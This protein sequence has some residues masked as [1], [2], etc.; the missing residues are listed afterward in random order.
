[1]PTAKGPLYKVAFRRR[2]ENRTD[3]RKRLG[4]IRSD[5]PRLVV[6]ASNKGIRA[7]FVRFEQAGDMTQAQAG[8]WELEPLGW[9]PQANAPTAYL[10]GLMAGT[11]A[12]KA[13]L[14]SFHID[15]GLSTASKGRILFAAGMGARDAGLQTELGDEL[16]DAKRVK[17]E[18]IAAYAK[19]LKSSNPSKFGQHFAR[20]AAKNIDVTALPALFDKTKARIASG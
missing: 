4:Q 6:R 19:E 9:M 3:Y 7:Q 14:K 5:A 8:S 11:R 17:G 18:H 10:V 15:I 13:G 20:Y 2:R 12:K 1:M 16:I